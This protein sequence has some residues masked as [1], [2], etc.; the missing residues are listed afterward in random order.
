MW[1]HKE[2]LIEIAKKYI[3]VY[4]N[5][6]KNKYIKK[7]QKSSCKML[8]KYNLSQMWHRNRR[9]GLHFVNEKLDQRKT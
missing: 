4:I 3:Y 5:K 8:Y 9:S 1:A 6:N 2:Y 7:E